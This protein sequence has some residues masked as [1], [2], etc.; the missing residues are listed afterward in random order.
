L[1]A[2]GDF[3]IVL[4]MFAIGLEIPLAR[5]NSMK[6]EIFG[7]GLLQVLY[8]LSHYIFALDIASSIIIAL[9]FSLSSTAV[10]LSYL[11]SSKDIY[12]PD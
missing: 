5:M 12:N 3:G 10:V 11:K 2:V 8:L 4:L 9:A 6:N 1:E 7:N